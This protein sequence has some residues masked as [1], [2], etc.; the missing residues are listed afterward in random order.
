[1]VA[2]LMYQPMPSPGLPAADPLQEKSCFK[3]I[4]PHAFRNIHPEIR[5]GEEQVAGGVIHLLGFH[6]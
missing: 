4:P 5:G 1:M 6:L 2:A 3:E